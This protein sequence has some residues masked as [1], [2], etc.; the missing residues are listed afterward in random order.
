[1]LYV[2]RVVVADITRQIGLTQ[3]VSDQFF[4]FNPDLTYERFLKF[5]KRNGEVLTGF[6]K[7]TGHSITITGD[8]YSY[9][10]DTCE[11]G[12]ILLFKNTQSID[13]YSFLIVKKTSILYNECDRMLQ[14]HGS[15]NNTISSTTHLI[16]RNSSIETSL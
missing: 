9:V 16:V 8:I 1:M 13:E 10:K 4:R 15:R 12:D 5:K 11:Y 3:K 6:I 14:I 2:K 7:K